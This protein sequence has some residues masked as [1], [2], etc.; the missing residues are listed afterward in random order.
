ME[1]TVFHTMLFYL[2]TLGLTATIVNP[3]EKLQPVFSFK[4]IYR[5][6]ACKVRDLIVSRQ[7]NKTHTKTNQTNKQT[8]LVLVPAIENVFYH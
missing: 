8:W 4:P 3:F 1:D 5:D 6:K 7:K 2:P